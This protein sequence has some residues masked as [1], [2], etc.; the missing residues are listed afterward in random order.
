MELPGIGLDIDEPKDLYELL[1][2]ENKTF[3]Q[4]FLRQLNLMKN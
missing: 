1:K 4:K 2:K 3:S